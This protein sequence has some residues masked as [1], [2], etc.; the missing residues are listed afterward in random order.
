M[1]QSCDIGVL[2][3]FLQKNIG[4]QKVHSTTLTRKEQQQVVYF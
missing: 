3:T 4:N 1:P 2:E